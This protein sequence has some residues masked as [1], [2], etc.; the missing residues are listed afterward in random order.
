MSISSQRGVASIPIVMAFGI[1]IVAVAIGVTALSY[2]EMFAARGSYDSARAL[3][4][5]DAGAR[6][7]LERVSRDQSYSCASTNCYTIDMLANGCANTNACA[8]VSVSAGVGT[9]T[10]PKI[11]TSQGVSGLSVRTLR[12]SVLFDSSQNGQISS[13]QWSEI[14]Q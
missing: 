5:A 4:Y 10:D 12:A 3:T 8:S 9:S 1:L 13:V 6:D 7:A 2:T 14:T 11:I